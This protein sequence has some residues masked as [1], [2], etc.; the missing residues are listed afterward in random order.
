MLSFSTTKPIRAATLADLQKEVER[1]VLVGTIKATG[2]RMSEAARLLGIERSGLYK[3]LKR[4]G[5]RVN[6]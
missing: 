2:G 5:L 3:K 6:K 1:R 4:H